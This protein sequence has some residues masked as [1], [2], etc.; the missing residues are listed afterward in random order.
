M[1]KSNLLELFHGSAGPAIAVHLISYKYTLL[2]E[3]E[4]NAI[5]PKVVQI[6]KSGLGGR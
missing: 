6:R 1:H 5:D 4:W 3:R 2:C